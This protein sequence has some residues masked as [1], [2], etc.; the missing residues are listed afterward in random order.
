MLVSRLASESDIRGTD[1]L[2]TDTATLIRTTDTGTTGRTMGTTVGRHF[3][4]T[5]VIAST[6][7]GIDTIIGTG[8]NQKTPRDFSSWRVN[9]PPAYF[10]GDVEAAGADG[11]VIDGGS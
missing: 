10:F 1:I 2:I 5:M 7:R 4:G 8:T 3:I 11:D 9:I 6:I